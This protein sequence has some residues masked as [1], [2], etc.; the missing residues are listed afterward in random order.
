MKRIL[1][2][3][4]LLSVSGMVLSQ[5]IRL[6]Q[7]VRGTIIDEQ[8]GNGL[9][10]A[11]IT[12]EGSNSASVADSSGNFKLKSIPIGRQTIRITLSGYEEAI[13]RNI[14]VTSSKEVVIEIRLKERIQKM[15]EVVLVA[16]RQKN[17]AINE[18]AVVSARQF[19]MDEAVRY[20]GSRNDPSRMAQN[21][22]GVS[23]TNDARND[24]VIRG[25]SPAG[26]LW[27]MDGI[28]IPNPNH[29]STLGA[30]GGPVSILNTNTLK[31]SDF[32]T[33]AFPSAYGNA[34]AGVFDMR[35][36]NGNDEKYEFLGQMGFNGF[37]LGVE[38]PLSKKTKSSFLF[39]YRYSMVAAIQSVGL[40]IG[41]GS[42]TPYYQDLHF[43]FNMPTKK[44][45]TF[46]WFGLGGESHI[47]F[48][49]ED[50]DEDDLY[51]SP[52]GSVRD[53]TY[54]SL[55]GVTGLTHTYF[56]NP[57]TSG[58]LTLA[59]SGSQFRGNEDIIEEDS[60]RR[61]AFDIRYLQVKYSAGYSINKKINSKNQF[62]IGFVADM[63]RLTLKQD[64]IKDGDSLQSNLVDSK[65]NASLLKAFANFNHRFTDKLSTN[66]GVYYQYFTLNNSYAIEP[67]WNIKYQFRPNQSLAFGV[68]VHSQL[69]P[70][71]VYFYQSENGSGGKELTNKHLDM[72]RSLHGVLGYD[73]NFSK[74]LRLKAEV[75][76]QYIYDAAVE[77]MPSSF[78]ML[79]AGA[80]FGFPDK[81]NLINDGNGYNYGFEL[82]IER[83]LHKGFYYLFTGSVFQSRYRGSDEVWRNTAFNGNYT[84]NLLG[85]KEIKLTER[86]SVGIDTKIA[87]AG[88]QRYTPFDKDASVAAG[89][90][91]YKEDEAYS[92]Q[93]DLYWRWDFKVSFTRNGRKATQKWYI[94]FQNVTANNNIYVRTLN[95]KTGKAG[96]IKQIG[97]F[98]NINYMITW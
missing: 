89:Y 66:L 97:F 70:L 13:V 64:L 16:G 88:G 98:P 1:F 92:L 65:E 75:Y 6:T 51:A 10:Y 53:R 52:D 35:M 43:K 58:K 79:N 84:A 56:F 44:F 40:N 76:G 85:G 63:N 4:A 96:E 94:D 8:S 72:A 45:G 37:E 59:V 15:E 42:A 60:S 38:G 11:S 3:L 54:K 47:N 7:T 82:T 67:R 90:V 22:A 36:R 80:D 32:L 39:N 68:G 12:V 20:A 24:I 33:S 2:L 29:F 21:F 27:R 31:N 87:L 50:N 41:T 95:P 49:P 46:S 74:Q 57:T 14:E 25:N 18:A 19:S 28:D 30:T 61:D 77:S 62:T 93:N 81:T 23:G 71:E 78:S 69:Q 55:T 17:K 5:E 34:L 83:F 91:I 86:T 73:I 26:V 48:K 9:G